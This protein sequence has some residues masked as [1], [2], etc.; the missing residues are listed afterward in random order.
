[1][2]CTNGNPPPCS[3]SPEPGNPPA[4]R[5]LL[6]DAEFT[7]VMRT[8]LDD[9]PD[10]DTDKASRAVVEALKFVSAAALFPQVPI[11]PTS[12]VDEGW[13]ALILHTHLYAT[14]CSSLGR[15]VHHYP[16]RPEAARR[17]PA[18]LT[19]TMALIE[20]AGYTPDPGLWVGR[21]EALVGVARHT[22]MPGGCGPINP[23]NC[24]SGGGDAD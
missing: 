16:E 23:G 18:V 5:S 11:S 7:G 14:L 15:T 22:P 9:N 1:M 3:S 2:A 19:R 24:A 13:H 12:E 6:S 10:W 21:R 4:V 8:V 17:D 20:Q